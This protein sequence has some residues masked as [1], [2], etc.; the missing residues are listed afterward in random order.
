MEFIKYFLK[1]ALMDFDIVVEIIAALA[2]IYGSF[3]LEELNE[4]IIKDILELNISYTESTLLAIAML[5]VELLIIPL[6]IYINNTYKEFK[7][8]KMYEEFDIIK[9]KGKK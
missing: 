8:E 7:R 9:R 3:K 6:S 2:L 1:K 5:I 4:Y